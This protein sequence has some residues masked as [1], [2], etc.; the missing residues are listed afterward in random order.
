MDPDLVILLG[1]AALVVLA[2]VWRLR[3]TGPRG[4]DG[5]RSQR[6]K[7]RKRHAFMTTPEAWA[8]R[9]ELLLDRRR[10]DLA[11]R[12]LDDALEQFPGEPRLERLRR[13]VEEAGAT[14]QD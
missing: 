14:R 8:G 12:L 4:V 3:E 10:P 11:G 7:A 2:L 5:G 9:A 1:A 6:G 13:R